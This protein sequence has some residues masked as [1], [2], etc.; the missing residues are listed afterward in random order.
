[1]TS[2][3]WIT[4]NGVAV[5]ADGSLLS[6]WRKLKPYADSFIQLYGLPSGREIINT[7]SHYNISPINTL[8]TN[9]NLYYI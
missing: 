2:N 8:R 3:R 4:L 6:V 9:T 5:K 7:T 1:M